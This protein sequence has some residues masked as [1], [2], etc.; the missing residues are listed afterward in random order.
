MNFIVF[1]DDWGRHPS[2][3]QHIFK[4]IVKSHRVLWVNTIGMR[5]PRF[6]RYDF[7]RIFSKF[8]SWIRSA[9]VSTEG[10]I[11][12]SPFMIPF[13]NIKM[14]RKL[15]KFILI[16]GIKRK[17]KKHNLS[18]PILVTTVPNISDVVGNINERRAIYYCVDDFIE[19]PEMLKE[20]LEHEENML[21]RKVDAVIV[22]SQ[23]LFNKLEKRSKRLHLLT[24]GV[25]IDHFNISSRKTTKSIK[26]MDV[27]KRPI[28]GYYGF[29]DARI[30]EEIISKIAN[31]SNWSLVIIGRVNLD[32]GFLNRFSNVHFIGPVNYQILSEYAR[33]FDVSILPYKKTIAIKA[34]NP[35]KF[36][37]YMALNSPIVATKVPE[38]E[39]YSRYIY[40]A[41]SPN[42][43]INCIEKSLKNS[44]S[45]EQ[46][47]RRLTILEN[48]SWERKAEQFLQFIENGF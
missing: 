27:I 35:L 22:T 9:Y 20:V 48:E 37:E 30:D 46:H 7:E 5:L 36:K 18:S 42:E 34:S 44:L 23:F 33:Y 21:L 43:F 13:T 40:T 32:I 14:V 1:S 39:K 11:V 38:L 24:H 4:R 29:F 6:S 10:I 41:G 8:Y 25:D 12:Y 15:N 17:L 45:K 2:S 47:I 19:W 26:V 16:H 31:R 28:I 3:C